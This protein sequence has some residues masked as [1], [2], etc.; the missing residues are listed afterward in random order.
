MFFKKNTKKCFGEKKLEKYWDNFVAEER[1]RLVQYEISATGKLTGRLV[2]LGDGDKEWARRTAKH[3]D[4]SV[5]E[6]V[7][8]PDEEN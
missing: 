7:F 2:L 8:D 6:P 1:Y 4:L 3:Y 5:T